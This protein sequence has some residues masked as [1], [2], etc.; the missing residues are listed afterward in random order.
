MASELKLK[1]SVL[2][3]RSRS[4][5]PGFALAF[6]LLISPHALLAATSDDAD[7]A[8]RSGDFKRAAGILREA[9][10][11]GDTDAQYRLAILYHQGRGVRQSDKKAVNCY[12]PTCLYT[13]CFSMHAMNN[14]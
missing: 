14:R 5:L 4:V 10:K 9:A 11:T 1:N 6:V 2:L 7:R 8:I 13:S 3:D 12:V